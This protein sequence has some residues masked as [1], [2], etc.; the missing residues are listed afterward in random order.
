[1]AF[2]NYGYG[3]Y[4][5]P[6]YY[7]PPMP[8]QLAQLRNG[9]QYNNPMMN[10]QPMQPQMQQQSPVQQPQQPVTQIIPQAQQP[11]L[12]GPVYVNGE[13]GM[14]GYLVAPGCSVLIF[15][16]DT[17]AH[18]FWIKTA[19]AFGTPSFK[20]YDYTERVNAHRTP[21]THVETAQAPIVDYVTREEWNALK[22]RAEALEAELEAL[23]AKKAPAPKKTVKENEE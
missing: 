2:N 5:A 20:T 7:A 8:D 10:Q 19:D 16:A 13:A 22:E 3:G 1:M 18:T 4:P 14:R 23:K 11:T 17:D 12:S 6:N 9:Q 21:E 15:D